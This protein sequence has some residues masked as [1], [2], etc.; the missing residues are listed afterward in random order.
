MSYA[1]VAV[2]RPVPGP[3]TYAIPAILEPDVRVGHVVLVPFG[4][5]GAETGYVVGLTADPAF[6]P[7]KIKPIH[8]LVDP[9]PAFDERQ[10]AFFQWIADYYVAPLG[11]VIHTAL[12]SEIGARVLRVVE[13]TEPGVL[14]LTRH[15]VDG[16]AA[17]VLREVIARPG[18]TKKGLL[19]RLQDELGDESEKALDALFRKGLVAWGEREIEGP[20]GR[21]RVATL[22]LPLDEA[23]ERVPARSTRM[24]ALID[25]VAGG[26]VDV[27]ALTAAQGASSSAAIARL[28]EL[29]VIAIHEREDRDAIDDGSPLGPAHPPVLNADQQAALAAIA[30]SNGTSL[31]FGVTGSGKT[32]VF[33]GAAREV[34][35]R[36]RQV[37]VLVPEI[38]LTPQLVGRFKARFGEGVAVL[39]SG[40]TGGERLGQWRRIRAG[41]AQVAVGARSALFAPFRDLGLVVVDEEH[42]DSYKQDDGVR[43]NARDLAVVLGR[44]HGSAVVL[45]SATPSLESW[46]NARTGRYALLRLP[47][48]ATKSAVPTVEIVDLTALEWPEDQPRPL[49]HPHVV[50]GLHEA[51][52]AGGKVIVLYN[53]RGYATMVQCTSCGGTYECP[54]CGITLTLHRS[55]RIVACHYC[56]L[57]LPFDQHCPAC[58]K[59][60]LE[61]L[62]KGTER[63]DEELRA[64]FPDVAVARMDADTTAVR[65]AHHRILAD[66]REGRSRILVGT[67]IV[68]KGHDFPDVQAAVVVSADHGFRMPDFRAAERT[69]ALLVQVAGRA[70]RG[71]R[72]GRVFLQTWTPDHY[73]LTH[74]DTPEG[75]YEAELKLRSTLRYPPFTRL[76]LIRLEGVD[77]D[78]VRD[79]AAA[80]G[81]ALKADAARATG[82]DILGP[83]P[84]ALAKLVG[85]WRWQ[86]VVRGRDVKAWH[87][88]VA[89]HAGLVYAAAKGGVRTTIDIDPRHLM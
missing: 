66:F 77:R 29:G 42:D 41:E 72:P 32:E 56:G 68:A 83:S 60:T 35:A 89:A 40:L 45:A 57:K 2:S 24:R 20:K 51:L 6:D 61:E 80:L 4:A 53:R 17:H 11:A 54:N 8:R 10:L 27:R 82:V 25:A 65:G 70:G 7:A 52:D 69:W 33:L 58:H 76:C 44:N 31:L 38:G 3:L 79:A 55:A 28:V 26:P 85:R 23:R 50:A 46:N 39:H 1:L 19:R 5:K 13:P 67:Q 71:D 49:F 47:H 88:F 21:I 9:E 84:A 48:R 16:A 87:G 37:L 74:L 62:G 34:L 59:P 43:Y 15:E 22:Q 81:R 78:R 36:G 18:L 63:V 12:P 14:A 75:F 73:V 30:A 86:L 64:L